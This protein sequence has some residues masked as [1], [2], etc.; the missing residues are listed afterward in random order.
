MKVQKQA[1]INHKRKRKRMSVYQ[2]I[3]H[4]SAELCHLYVNDVNIKLRLLQEIRVIS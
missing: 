2:L 1:V 4:M 3:A